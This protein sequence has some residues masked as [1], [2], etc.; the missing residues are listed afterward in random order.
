LGLLIGSAPEK[1][2]GGTKT[3]MRKYYRKIF[4]DDNGF[5]GMLFSVTKL[6]DRIHGFYC[7]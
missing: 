3:Q 1:L 5:V 4:L 7:P 2:V 6:F